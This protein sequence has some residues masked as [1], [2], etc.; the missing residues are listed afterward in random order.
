[1]SK[2]VMKKFKII[3]AAFCGIFLSILFVSHI[4]AEPPETPAAPAPEEAPSFLKG[5]TDGKWIASRNVSIRS[6][7][8]SSSG[9]VVR[10]IL[11]DAVDV[12]AA[13]NGWSKVIHVDGKR[14]WVESKYLRNVWILVNKKAGKLKLMEGMTSKGEWSIDLGQDPVGDKVK[15]GTIEPGHYRT[16]EGELYICSLIPN[17][18]FYKAF[19]LSYPSI[20]HADRGLELGLIN[21]SQHQQIV[22]AN[23]SRRVPAQ[24]TNLGGY[25]EIHGNGTGGLYNWT[26]G[27]IALKNE[28]MDFLWDKI[29]VGTPVVVTP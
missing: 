11:G 6:K 13:E 15:S 10:C 24:D 20:R 14:G 17:S 25:V 16:P 12:A 27:C 21:K 19:L 26:L 29:I 4:F 18:R 1:M 2:I 7:A 8:S 9:V 3:M 23:K 22:G 28:V 5:R